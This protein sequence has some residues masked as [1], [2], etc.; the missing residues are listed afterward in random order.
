MECNYRTYMVTEWCPHCE[1]EVEMRWDVETFGYKAFCPVCGKRLMLCDECRH[2][3]EGSCDYDNKTDSC[4]H[5]PAVPTSDQIP[6]TLRERDKE[7]EKLWTQFADVPMNPETECMEEGF[8]SFPAGSHREDIW[9]WFDEQHSKG[10]VYL[11]YGDGIDH[12][13]QLAK[14]VYLKQLCIECESQTCQ[15]NHRGECRFALVHERKAR[16]TD[17]NGCIDYDYQNR[18]L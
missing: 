12:T 11:L 15:Y 6:P 16:I 4:R 5:N 18:A 8:L 14:L 17:D 9:H 1:N 2:S 7:L 10:V 13:D 3:G